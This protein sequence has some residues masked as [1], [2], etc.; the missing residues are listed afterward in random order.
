M[1]G[2]KNEVKKNYQK[3]EIRQKKITASSFN[4][5]LKYCLTNLPT[6]PMI[7]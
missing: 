2:N 5:I 4:I 1:K 3:L 7:L 6:D